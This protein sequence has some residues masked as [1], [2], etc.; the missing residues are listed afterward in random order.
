MDDSQIFLKVWKNALELVNARGYTYDQ[1]YDTINEEEMKHLIS[2]NGLF[3]MG[4]KKSSKILIKLVTISKVK[5]VNIKEIVAEIVDE[6]KDSNCSFEIIII[7]KNKP[8]S[9]I[10]K[11]EKDKEYANL[12]IMYTK[13]FMFNPTKHSL[14]PKHTKLP[15]DEI[16]DIVKYYALSSKN[17]LPI[18]LKDDAIVRYYNFKPGDVIKIESTVGT[19]NTNY[20]YYRCVR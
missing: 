14:V 6:L 17:Q 8:T 1:K 11:L 10:K 9:I 4:E 2:N 3:I 16:N 19:M 7:L 18:I 13:Q 15:E 12:Q 5:S 20:L